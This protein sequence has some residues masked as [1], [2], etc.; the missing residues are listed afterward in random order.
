MAIAAGALPAQTSV[1]LRL[2]PRL[3]DTLHMR[4]DQQMDMRGR[5]QDSAE[6]ERTIANTLRVRARAVPTRRVGSATIL[7]TI[8]DS[9]V[10]SSA[11]GPAEL[12]DRARRSFVGREVEVRVLPDGAMEVLDQELHDDEPSPLFGHMP[13]VLP[14]VAVSVGDQWVREMQ[15]P[16]RG[17]RSS[18]SAVRVT[19]RLD[20][21]GRDGRIAY[22]SVRGAFYERAPAPGGA[23]RPLEG[24]LAGVIE[25]DRQ[26]GWIRDSRTTITMRSDVRG[27]DPRTAPMEVWMRITQ[28]LQARTTQ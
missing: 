3:G 4:L 26:V 7:T 15:L 11:L 6:A 23:E 17:S 14:S 25:F 27:P 9:L 19:F 21:L 13:P 12:M 18:A 24:S 1:M 28:R 16:L 2:A 10:V 20:S 22:I 5:P 8:T